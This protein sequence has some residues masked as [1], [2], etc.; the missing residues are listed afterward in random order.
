MQENTLNNTIYELRGRMDRNPYSEGS[1]DRTGP[2]KSPDRSVAL[3]RKST[4]GGA[5]TV[6]EAATVR[7]LLNRLNHSLLGCCANLLRSGYRAGTAEPED[8]AQAAW[9]KVLQYLK[10]RI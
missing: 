8:I 9:T 10:Q 4:A 1:H 7:D 6:S 3:L 2:E 5:L